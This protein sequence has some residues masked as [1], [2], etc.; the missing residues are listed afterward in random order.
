M[1]FL[2]FFILILCSYFLAVFKIYYDLS[3]TKQQLKKTTKKQKKMNTTIKQLKRILFSLL[4][5]AT[6]TTTTPCQAQ[7]NTAQLPRQLRVASYNIQ[8]GVGM[9]QKLDYKRIA[10]VLENINPDVVAVQEVD[11]MTHRTNNTYSLGEIADH[12]RY[13]ASFSPAI[14]FDGGKYGIG[15]LSRK[16]PI[17]IEQHAL[18]GREEARTLLVAEFDD[19]VFAATHLSLTEA[20]LMASASII[21]N[22]AKKCSKPFIIAG[23]LNALPDS[24]FIKQLEKNFHICNNK[25]KSWPAD[26]P[27][28][29]LDYIAVY[30]SYGDVRRPGPAEKGWE[31]YRPYV[32]EPAVTLHSEV[33][34]TL[35]SDHRPIFADIVLPTPVDKL[36]T[37]QP[38]LQL[39]TPT[40]MN[41][42]FQ[43]NSVCH[44]WIEYGTDSLHTQRARTILDGQEVCYDIENNIKLDNLKPGT[45]YYYRVCAME[46]LYKG[47]YSN[48][49]GT[50]TLRTPF[51]SFRTPAL[52]GEDFT[53]LVFND[54]HEHGETLAHLKQLAKD[55]DYDF[56]IFNGDC[57]PEPRNREHAISMIHSLADEVDGA[58]K[59]VIFLRGN[60]EI[61]N[62]Y[63]AGMHHQIGYYNDK[64]YSAFTW[65]NTR[66]LLL[67]LGEDKPDSNPVYGGLNN[68]TQL[69]HDQAEFI[70]KELSSREFKSARNH[71]LISHI[72]VFG[73]TDSY[74]PCTELWGPM[75]S[76]APFNVAL[77][78]HTHEAKYYPKGV[79]GCR[80]PVY[81]GGGYNKNDATVAVLTCRGG[82]LSMRV[83][84][85]NPDTR[86]TLNE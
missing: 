10:D 31:Q 17:R 71:V 26:N 58:E 57:L 14:S 1:L 13:Y 11:S 6:I 50:D 59:P 69:R 84:S 19:Y 9:D 36:L 52:N 60:H 63:S 78:A 49:F 33:V 75:L 45:R 29:C 4:L 77:A 68:F 66:F 35:A 76:R 40:S 12:M 43:T 16:R 39:A 80:Y 65:G 25:G 41:V 86:W 24:P 22:I 42:M 61:R 48:H 79:D 55:I 81:V 28:E 37:T 32:G 27:R 30:K 44:C 85:D 56:V 72:P 21:E 53:C 5:P 62:F 20:D 18:P 15:I 38:Y 67:D 34:N 8:H 73:N 64:T 7:T 2:L 54:L 23:D 47:A 74:R 46:I 83:L 3:H 70:K 82:K 51:Y